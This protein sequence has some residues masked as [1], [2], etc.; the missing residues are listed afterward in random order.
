MRL[1]VL[2][3]NTSTNNYVA[4]CKLCYLFKPQFQPLKTGAITTHARDK[5]RTEW[6]TMCQE[7]R[8]VPSISAQEENDGNEND[9]GGWKR[10]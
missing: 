9:E 1:V 3:S 5:E 8:T 10:A 6:L 4:M 7:I 2:V